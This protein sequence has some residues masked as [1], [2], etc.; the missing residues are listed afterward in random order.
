MKR[1][2]TLT[3]IAAALV[4]AYGGRLAWR[5]HRDVVSMEANDIPVAD[6]IKKLRWQT[7]EDIELGKDVRAQARVTLRVENQPLETVLELVS[8]QVGSRWVAAYPLYTTKAKLAVARKL[9][10]GT[11]PAPQFGWTNWNARP[12]FAALA[13]VWSVGATNAPASAEGGG[14][15]P[16]GGPGMMGGFGGPGGGFGGF[17]GPDGGGPAQPVTI[18]WKDTPPM[19]AAASLRRFGQVKVVPED[20]TLI[21]AN[22]QL[23]DVP[24]DKAVA[25]LAKTVN[26]K[27]AKFYLIGEARG[28][29]P[30]PREQTQQR[31]NFNPEQ[32]RERFQQIASSPEFQERM[33]Q[34]ENRGLL[35]STPDQRVDRD[36]RRA[37]G[38][39]GG[40]GRPG[41]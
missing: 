31:P 22:L 9:A 8:E 26:R 23:K 13:A 29:R 39:R 21:K 3:L 30:E 27:W 38:G 18:E 7:W 6:V 33:E 11:L 41:R 17:G 15:P 10:L 24:M 28:P 34:R 40:G 16:A 32:M 25:Q 4:L 20:G 14:A 37:R 19:V 1:S 36:R 12:N 5:A 2:L 35:N